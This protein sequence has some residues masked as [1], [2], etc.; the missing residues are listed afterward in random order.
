LTDSLRFV[1][2]AALSELSDPAQVIVTVEGEDI[3][4][5]RM[6]ERVY[7]VGN[8]CTHEWV[9]LDD[10]ILHEETCE[11]ECPMHEGRFD[12]RTGEATH[13]PC[14]VALPS[15]PVRVEGDDVLVGLGPANPLRE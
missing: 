2:V 12:L 4:L 15:Y 10:G 5:V 6:G 1:R 14:E 7:A 3:L 11:I 9:W 13:E 8:E